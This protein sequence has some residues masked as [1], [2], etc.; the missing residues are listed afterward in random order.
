M[1]DKYIYKLSFYESR[2]HITS[3]TD[4][5]YCKLEDCLWVY[6]ESYMYVNKNYKGDIICSDFFDIQVI[7]V[8]NNDDRYE[9][10][11]HNSNLSNHN[12]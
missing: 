11:V 7:K 3:H 6:D 4:M 8:K 1:S 12:Q 10:A 9:S 2:R 5:Y